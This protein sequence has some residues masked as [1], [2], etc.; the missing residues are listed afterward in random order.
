MALC[1]VAGP[2]CAKIVGVI[3]SIFG[4]SRGVE[5]EAE[6]YEATGIGEPPLRYAGDKQH[7]G[8]GDGVAVALA[9][10]AEQP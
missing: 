9:Y 2:D 4:R 6:E 5:P 3:S 10:L 1:S 7:D 8:H